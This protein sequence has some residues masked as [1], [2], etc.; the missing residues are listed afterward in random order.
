[1][2]VTVSQIGSN[3][4]AFARLSWQESQA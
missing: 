2:Y 3:G 4:T 1:L